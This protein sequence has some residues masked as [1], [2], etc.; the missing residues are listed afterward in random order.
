MRKYRK[1]YRVKKK[2][3]I[4]RNRFFWLGV[5]VL[6][7]SVGIF[8]LI[9]F[10]SFFQIKEIK[11]TG[12][13]KV[14]TESLQK[15]IQ[16]QIEQKIILGG[17]WVA[18]S[19]SIFLVNINRITEDVL[20]NFPHIAGVKISRDFPSALNI[21][22]SERIGLTVWCQGEKCFL[23]DGEG[24]IFDPVRNDISNGVEE[25]FKIQNLMSTPELK[26]GEKVIEKEKLNKI[27]EI[28]SKL[29]DYNPP[30]T[31]PQERAPNLKI[32]EVS[33]ISE[34]RLNAKTSEGW[35]IYFNPKKDIDWQL[36][37][38]RAVLEEEI[39]PEKRK[40]LEYIELRFGNFAPYKYRD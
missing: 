31:L 18:S 40:D 21:I 30:T 12:N 20:N 15:I 16:N 7:I 34:E 24:V 35:E 6:I 11:I 25:I 5:L 1:P 14:L 23:L 4:S 39:P 37:K 17:G 19:K 32:S 29:R 38:L 26:L 13:Q 28:E 33:I 10:A 9:C 2:K 27:L 22:I 36:T 3:S 8:Y